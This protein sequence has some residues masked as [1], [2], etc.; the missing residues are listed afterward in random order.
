MVDDAL[1][2]ACRI[3]QAEAGLCRKMSTGDDGTRYCL[4]VPLGR[5]EGEVV[6]GTLVVRFLVMPLA[7]ALSR[8]RG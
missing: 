5:L 4:G 8:R 7:A 1:I 3:A 2:G 6:F